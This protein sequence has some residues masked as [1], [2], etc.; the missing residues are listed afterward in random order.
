M[1]GMTA[2]FS[3]TIWNT[4]LEAKRGRTSA[5]NLILGKYR[6]PV[7]C[8]LQSRGHS[9]EDAEDLVQEVFLVV[10]RDDLLAKADQERSRF[11][12]F[13]LAVVRNVLSNAVRVRRASKRGGG[14]E[15]VRVEGLLDEL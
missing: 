13:L 2:A 11:R 3:T 10:V 1:S 14:A 4:I 8:Y 9:L 7:V 6:A 12:T 15:P 5:V